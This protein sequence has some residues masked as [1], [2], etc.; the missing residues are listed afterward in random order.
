[1][2]SR[3]TKGC[4]RLS[5]LLRLVER[6]STCYMSHSTPMCRQTLCWSF[7]DA[8]AFTVQE[9]CSM[10]SQAKVFKLYSQM[11]NFWLLPFFPFVAFFL[12]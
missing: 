4:H 12:N 10:V 6:V 7:L 5:R 1:M 11:F 2:E 9:E 8:K 3:H